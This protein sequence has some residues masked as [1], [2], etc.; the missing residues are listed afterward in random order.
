MSFSKKGPGT[1][2]VASG[3][4]TN[5]FVIRGNGGTNVD[6]GNSTIRTNMG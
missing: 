2:V 1:G 6:I 4:L 5:N 3:E